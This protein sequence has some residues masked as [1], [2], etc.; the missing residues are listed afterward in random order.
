MSGTGRV[1]LAA[2]GVADAEHRV[3]K[4]IRQHLPEARVSIG[5]VE[6][7]AHPPRIVEEF[8]VSYTVRLTLSV[9]G[10]DVEA[11]RSAAF[12]ATREMLSG[13]RYERTVWD[14]ER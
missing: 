8:T 14:V 5:S 6:R 2:F 1:E 10:E 11:A 12:R 13:S 7:S 4:E 3:E 9:T